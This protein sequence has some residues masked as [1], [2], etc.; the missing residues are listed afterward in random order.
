MENL[1]A[2]R[3][4][5]NYNAHI[6]DLIL[7]AASRAPRRDLA[8]DFGAG[9]GTFT[10]LVAPYFQQL[11]AV[12]VEDDSADVLR[13]Q[14]YQVLSDLSS[15]ADASVDFIFSVS[16]LEHIDDEASVLSEIRRVL[17]PGG[18]VFV[19]VPAFPAL[20]SQMDQLVGHRRRYTAAG[21]ARLLSDVGLESSGGRYV[22]SLGGLASLAMRAFRFH[23]RLTSSSVRAYDLWG[24][25]FSRRLDAI[26]GGA[27]G[28][29]VFIEAAAPGNG[30]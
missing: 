16:V 12:E 21:L 25:P 27:F 10:R 11:L 17:K 13:H 4:A 18:K 14:G 20:W 26:L 28:K 15:V 30:L 6:A 19:Y 2:M 29:N 5:R 22:D 24:F 1:D 8:I 3:A 23:G 7:R 9:L